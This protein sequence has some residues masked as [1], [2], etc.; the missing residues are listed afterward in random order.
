M[1]GRQLEARLLTVVKMVGVSGRQLEARL[2]TVVFW[3][4]SFREKTDWCLDCASAIKVIHW[5]TDGTT[6][7]LLSPT[8]PCL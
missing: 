2:K 3:W 6:L 4:L 7:I 5:L 8:D 1:S